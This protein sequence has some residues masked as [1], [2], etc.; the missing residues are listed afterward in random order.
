MNAREE[1]GTEASSK[2]GAY[3]GF[4]SILGS[5]ATPLSLIWTLFPVLLG[6]YIS[7]FW[8]TTCREWIAPET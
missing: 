7:P 6:F 2:M 3:D 8:L 5:R 4:S 1:A